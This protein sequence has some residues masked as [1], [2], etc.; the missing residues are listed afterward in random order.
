[1]KTCDLRL[2]LYAEAHKLPPWMEAWLTL[3]ASRHRTVRAR[4]ENQTDGNDFAT[5]KE[6]ERCPAVSNGK[7]AFFLSKTLISPNFDFRVSLMY[8]HTWDFWLVWNFV[9]SISIFLRYLQNFY[10]FLYEL[11]SFVAPFH[12]YQRSYKKL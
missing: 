10:T 5:H 8:V 6:V 2:C 9:R 3:I 1:M 12:L 11:L 4:A 7:S